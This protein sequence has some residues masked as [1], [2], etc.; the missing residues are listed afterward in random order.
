MKT[1]S[2]QLLRK[3]AHLLA[4][5]HRDRT[6]IAVRKLVLGHGVDR[7][8][9]RAFPANARAAS[10]RS[11]T[12]PRGGACDPADGRSR[13]LRASRSSGFPRTRSNRS[14]RRDS[15]RGWSRLPSS[16]TFRRARFGG[17]CR[18]VPCSLPLSVFSVRP[19]RTRRKTKGTKGAIGSSTFQRVRAF[20]EF[21][22]NSGTAS[23]PP[24][25]RGL[26]PIRLTCGLGAR[27]D[28]ELA[29]F[30]PF[31][32]LRALRDLPQSSYDGD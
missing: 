19:R 26:T 6:Q 13:A 24:L 29:P 10:G 32:F 17:G 18:P 21:K 23:S 28:C 15:S 4:G 16:R 7:G 14:G 30:V 25:F 22:G 31:A 20:I 1:S 11:C 2:G 8:L 3:H 5:S 27:F 9:N 12:S